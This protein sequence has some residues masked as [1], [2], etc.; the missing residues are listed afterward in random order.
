MFYNHFLL[1]LEE[2][3]AL[4]LAGASLASSPCPGP[5]SGNLSPQASQGLSFLTCA[6]SNDRM[7][8]GMLLKGLNHII[9]IE[10]LEE[11]LVHRICLVN[12]TFFS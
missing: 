12:V 1:T 5:G 2:E 6:N 10:H 3:G 9:D 4:A 11:S 8:L 7:P